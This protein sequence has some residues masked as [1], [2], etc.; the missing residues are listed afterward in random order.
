[1]SY[2]LM[3]TNIIF[4]SLYL[5]IL[6]LSGCG[7]KRSENTANQTK[8]ST[9]EVIEKT[10]ATSKLPELMKA[11]YEA[12]LADGIDFKREGYPSFVV[13]TSG[14]S[15]KESFGRW[16]D[17]D[18]ILIE[19]VDPL[20][21]QFTVTLKAAAFI[22]NI[23]TSF[24]MIIGE[25]QHTF[26]IDTGS[27]EKMTTITLPFKVKGG[28]K[29]IRIMIPKATSPKAIAN[30]LDERRLGIALGLLQIKK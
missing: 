17:G 14:I 9:A 22:P 25:T 13:K 29:S 1:M 23:G 4:L 18:E 30:S 20:P 26:E 16:S 19:L 24:Q 11:T 8:H 21:S 10:V 3:K 15:E 12:T 7:E 5:I 27:P 28:A 6:F 2:L